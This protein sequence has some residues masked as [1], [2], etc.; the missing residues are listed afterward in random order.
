MAFRI[1]TNDTSPKL[2]VT[3]QDASGSVVD[4]TSASARFHMKAVGA[5][6]LK[7]DQVASITNASGGKVQYNWSSIDTDT[8]G[9]YYGEI[10][11]TYNDGSVETFPNNDYFTIIIKED[12]D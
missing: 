4:I 5:T 2:G 9:T 3:L 12:L 8:S 11:I 10:E 1:K 7:V 6:D